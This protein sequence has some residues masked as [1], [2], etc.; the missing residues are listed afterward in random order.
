MDNFNIMINTYLHICPYCGTQLSIQHLPVEKTV[1]RCPKCKKYIVV[2]NYGKDTRKPNVYN[3]PKCGEEQIFDGRPVL[4][5]CEKCNNIYKTSAH[6]VGMLELGLLS[7]GDK[8]ELPYKK[9][10]DKYICAINKWLSLSKTVKAS[11]ISSVVACIAIIIGLY[12][13][14]LPP[15]INT[16]MA[17]ADMDSLWKEFSEKNPYNIQI[18]CIRHYDDNSKVVIISEPSDF[19][20]E[21]EL[22]IFFEPY[23]SHVK[24]YKRKIGFDGWMRDFVVAFNDLSDKHYDSFTKDLANLLYK[25]DYKASLVDL[26][27]MLE[28]TPYLDY[29]LNYNI[30]TE[31]LKEWFIDNEE[32]IIPLEDKTNNVTNLAS[33]LDNYI[34]DGMQLYTSAT[35]GFV[36][37]AIDKS[38]MPDELN[39]RINARKFSLDSDLILGAISKNNNVAII[40][41]ERCIPTTQLP[42]MRTETLC[43]LSNTTDEELSQSYER[44]NLFAGKQTGSDGGKDYAP[45]LLSDA[46][47]HTEYGNILNVTDQMLKSWS[48]NGM[49]DYIDFNYP[50]PVFWGFD[51]GAMHDLGV[52]Q[53]TYN[54]NTEGVGYIV[55]DS[56]YSVYALNRTGSLPV[57]YIPGDATQTVE[58]DPV[59]QAEQ[60]AYNFFSSLS[61]P[62]LAKVV[63][64]A[65]M[66]QIFQNYDIHMQ[67]NE[68]HYYGENKFVM[69]YELE[70]EATNILQKLGKYNSDDRDKIATFYN[71]KI[72]TDGTGLPINDD[73][74]IVSNNQNLPKNPFA[75]Y[76]YLSAYLIDE[77]DSVRTADFAK[78]L[79]A[80]ELIRQIDTLHNYIS[81]VINDE[82]FI[83]SLGKA[84]IDRNRIDDIVYSSENTL[85][86]S[87]L[88]A[89][90]VPVKS[91][92]KE[93]EVTDAYN[94][95]FN[96]NEHIKTFTE[97]FSSY[98]H[99]KA[100]S[101]MVEANADR[102]RTWMKTP[103]VV[104]SWSLVDSINQ[105]GGHNLNSRVTRFRI[106][107]DLKS[108][109][110]RE[111]IVGNKKIIEV[112]R[113]DSKSH[114]IDQSYLRRVGRL[115]DVAIKGKAVK[116]RPRN[117]IADVA[118]NRSSRGFN[119]N[120]HTITIGKRSFTYADKEYESL[121]ALICDFCKS[122]NSEDVLNLHIECLEGSGI[123]PK[124]I[125]NNINCRLSRGNTMLPMSKF[126]FSHA[127][128]INQGD[129]VL[130]TIPIKSGIMDLGSTSSINRAGFGGSSNIG[131]RVN[132]CEGN[133]SF[134][135]VNKSKI[136][137]IISV[138]KEFFRSS[139]GYFNEFRLKMLF[140][141]HGIDVGVDVIPYID[142]KVNNVGVTESQYI[143]IGMLKFGKHQLYD[144]Q[145]FKEEEIA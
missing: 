51:K 102:S 32:P 129:N 57:S 12:I 144:I 122:S 38:D 119:I 65:A 116:T 13:I 135:I 43:L 56:E 117:I 52:S 108:G 96:K 69:P 21:E 66:Y 145:L 130:F 142:I 91:K 83:S 94:A 99:N 126:D 107:D 44:N 74:S 77:L 81:P 45:I 125:I 140:K 118:S 53:L 79:F 133:I 16:S 59:Y 113:I 4:I 30:T 61:N 73:Y 54:W 105:V 103:T 34:K 109:Q 98:N 22:E 85:P 87:T 58:Q 97:I 82:K 90:G 39:Y 75:L 115:D 27:T 37:W 55:E 19:V 71:A 5:K 68:I 88:G 138:L 11:I 134:K 50:K 31:E 28:H 141:E 95:V 132:V 106:A 84:M 33:V 2:D 48:E 3:C 15:A 47:W 35:P 136:S 40:A 137:K 18:E 25:T 42:P 86:Q 17:Y 80:S 1:S 123:K 63:Q 49:I 131:V 124:M 101:L 23:N 6:G 128:Q 93:E 104:E 41:R 60:N 10:K 127:T 14:S 7:R 143:I 26:S 46:L 76:Y 20:S 111:I 24:T 8:G 67:Y 139:K 70:V 29:D 110:T 100:K 89:L 62:E 36:I 9:K 121:D 92:S 78:L 114:I 64:Y 112:S 72:T 120:D